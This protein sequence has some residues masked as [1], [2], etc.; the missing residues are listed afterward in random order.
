MHKIS[1]ISIIVLLVLVLSEISSFYQFLKLQL[2][3]IKKCTRFTTKFYHFHF[4][5]GEEFTIIKR[6]SVMKKM[7]KSYAQRARCNFDNCFGCH[8]SQ[9]TAW[10][11][12]GEYRYIWTYK[13]KNIGR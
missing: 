5:V 13:I 7:T 8:L 9:D 10:K 6:P 12:R 4:N 1:I 3:I 11:V 2:P